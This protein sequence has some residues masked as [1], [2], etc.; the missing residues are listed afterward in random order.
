MQKSHSAVVLEI[1]KFLVKDTLPAG[2]VNASL[3]QPIPTGLPLP[4]VRIGFASARCASVSSVR[5]SAV[6]IPGGTA[7]RVLSLPQREEFPV[8][9]HGRRSLRFFSIVRSRKQFRGNGGL[10]ICI[11]RAV[12]RALA[13][14]L[15]Q[16]KEPVQA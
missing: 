14:S 4:S 3:A 16:M 13:E 2:V 1:G 9:L 15:Q 12:R 7:G 8:R 5:T 6:A 10:N 11:V